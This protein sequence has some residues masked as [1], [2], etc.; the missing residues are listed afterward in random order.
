MSPKR[1]IASTVVAGLLAIAL[2]SLSASASGI[3]PGGTTGNDI[4]YP[5][6][7]N[8]YPAFQSFG[9][10]GVT[11]GRA[12]THNS[13]LASEFGW[14]NSV[15]TPAS[16]YMNINGAFGST[17]PKG[18]SGPAGTCRRGD[19]SCI[20]Y[21]Y[22]YN[23]ASDSYTW[24]WSQGASAQQWWLDVETANSWWPQA[25]LNQR[26]IQG[27]L[28]FFAQKGLVLGIYSTNYQWHSLMGAYS[29]GLPVWYATAADQT[30]A[31]SYCSTAFNF[32]GGGVWLV[33]Y[34]AN[35]S[36]ADYACP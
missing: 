10:V 27:A 17:A 3:Y 1:L 32:A 31:S 36:D 26:V 14:A 24:A 12:F 5:Q 9:L 22:G 18:N 30:T 25:S 2:L 8:G 21:N 29:P 28:D 33:Q 15:A 23:A 16:L 13:C 20:A 19:K 35:G 6:C 7:G 4:G 11:A 34:I